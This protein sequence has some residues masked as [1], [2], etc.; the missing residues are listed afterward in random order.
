MTT[1]AAADARAGPWRR[2]AD[3]RQLLMNAIL[4]LADISNPCRPWAL[5]KYWSDLVVEEFFL[6][7]PAL[8][9]PC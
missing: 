4:H 1:A 9:P 6:Q 2:S 5:C 8:R 7:V 3:M